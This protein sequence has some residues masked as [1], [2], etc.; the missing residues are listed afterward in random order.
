MIREFWA[1]NYLSIRDKQGL[2]FLAKDSSSELVAEIT[3][4]VF[5]RGISREFCMVPT[6]RENQ[7]C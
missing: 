1:K 5:L 2:N 4:G 3:D 7:I 6:L